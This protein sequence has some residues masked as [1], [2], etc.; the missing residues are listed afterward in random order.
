MFKSQ[1]LIESSIVLG[2]GERKK[3]IST[4]FAQ[5]RT[6]GSTYGPYYPEQISTPGIPPSPRGGPIK[7]GILGKL[8]TPDLHILLLA[9]FCFA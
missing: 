8:S 1:F 2:N 5:N 7:I 9:Y 6:R 3:S 4:D